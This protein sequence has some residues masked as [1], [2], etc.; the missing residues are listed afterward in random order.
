MLLLKIIVSDDIAACLKCTRI[1]KHFGEIEAVRGAV[2][3][4]EVT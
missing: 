4:Q 2:V 3:N 1:F